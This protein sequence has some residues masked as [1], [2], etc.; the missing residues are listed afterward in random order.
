MGL[1]FEAFLDWPA[2]DAWEEALHPR[3]PEGKA[4]G[5]EFTKKAD[6]GPASALFNS[7]PSVGKTAEDLIAATGLTDRVA[8][9]MK[10][11]AGGEET[12]K[13]NKV[14]G[15]YTPERQALHDKIINEMLTP[16]KVKAAHPAAGQKPTATFLGGRGGSGKSSLTKEGGPVDATKAIMLNS[17]DVQAKLPGYE[18]WNAAL[19]HDE[20]AEIVSHVEDVAK[21][22]GLNVILDA[23]MRSEAGIKAKVESFRKAGYEVEG[24]YMFAPPELAAERALAR[25]KRG[26]EHGRY[27]PTTYTLGST[28]NEQT[29]DHMLPTFKRWSLYK[30]TG[31]KPEL[32]SKGGVE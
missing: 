27:V 22:L 30:N 13:Q 11:I 16:D 1:D 14:D 10:K 12:I 15:K 17:D 8:E 25:F 24:H 29:F 4:K 26:G 20:A 19:Y 5:G 6:H 3:V 32:V 31:D 28:T 21:Q 9:V 18:G 2:F 7:H 23:T